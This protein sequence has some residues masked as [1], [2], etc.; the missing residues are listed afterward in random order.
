MP[1]YVYIAI[2]L[3]GF[4]ADKDGGIDFLTSTPNPDNNDFGFASFMDSVDG[5]VMGRKTFETVCGFGGEWGYSKRVFV[6][7]NTMTA[8]PVGYEDKAEVV[9][10]ELHSIMSSL[11]ERG[12]KNMYIDGGIT[13][14][15]FLK[16]GLID[17]LI[18]TTVPVILGGGSPLFSSLSAPVSLELVKSE[19]LLSALVKNHY[20]I[21]K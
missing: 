3:D 20:C 9:T 11:S 17:E 14:Q 19:V 15:N 5:L 18:V 10:G 21:K 13:I 2:S 6:L 16:E 1:N 7:S 4:I 8:V 12:Y